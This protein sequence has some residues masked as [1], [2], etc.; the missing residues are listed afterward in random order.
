M[1][2]GLE[3]LNFYILLLFSVPRDSF[4]SALHVRVAH[5]F[6]AR[7]S[8]LHLAVTPLGQYHGKMRRC[9]SKA[10]HLS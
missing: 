4:L 6:A 7:I 8:D 9:F 3:T 1:Q 5:C 2:S 10:V